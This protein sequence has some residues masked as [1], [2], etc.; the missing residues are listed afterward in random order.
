MKH[1]ADLDTL[2][3]YTTSPGLR[4]GS[5]FFVG[6]DEWDKYSN[7]LFRALVRHRYCRFDIDIAVAAAAVACLAT[8]ATVSTRLV[9]PNALA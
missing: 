3:P 5:S 8:K 9:L 4:V 1:F 7:P 6:I 2:R